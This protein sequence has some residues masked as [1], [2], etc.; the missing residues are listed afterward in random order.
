MR[1][2]K[3]S[4]E[5]V[6]DEPL[7]P[8]VPAVPLLPDVPEVPL[9]DDFLTVRE[10]AKWIKLSESHVYFLVNQNKVPFAKLGGKLLFDKDK[11]RKWIEQNSIAARKPKKKAKEGK[12]VDE[13]VVPTP[14]IVPLSGSVESNGSVELKPTNGTISVPAGNAVGVGM[15]ISITSDNSSNE[16]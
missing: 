14:E 10:L 12:V 4:N 11:I 5:N 2:S 7:A 9:V 13:V 8:E 16:M 1:N 15:G 3:K 6:P